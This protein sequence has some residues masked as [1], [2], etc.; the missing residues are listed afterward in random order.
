MRSRV[1]VRFFLVVNFYIY[2]FFFIY[3]LRAFPTDYYVRRFYRRSYS[4]V[5]KEQQQRNAQRDII[6]RM[7]RRNLK[8][9]NPRKFSISQPTRNFAFFLL[10]TISNRSTALRV[11]RTTYS[12]CTRVRSVTYWRKNSCVYISS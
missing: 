6:E 9:K 8:K 1:K 7:C 10:R 3:S 4:A 11:F 2:I 5:V 12:V